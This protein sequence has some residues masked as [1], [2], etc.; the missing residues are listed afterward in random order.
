[1][2]R[3]LRKRIYLFYRFDETVP[4]FLSIKIGWKIIPG[5][6][7]GNRCFQTSVK[8]TGITAQQAYLPYKLLGIAWY[9]AIY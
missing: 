3:D 1:M 5:C 2:Q 7:Y 9:L 8:Q 6:K 4:G